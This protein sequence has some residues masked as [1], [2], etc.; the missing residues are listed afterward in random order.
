MV[1]V[2][3]ERMQVAARVDHPHQQSLAR[4]HARQRVV[5]LCRKPVDVVLQHGV[6]RV[7]AVDEPDAWLGRGGVDGDWLATKDLRIDLPVNG[8]VDFGQQ[9][10]ILAVVPGSGVRIGLAEACDPVVPKS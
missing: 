2:M 8:R 3:V 6:G 4:V 5:R 7:A 1:A 10:Q 9:E